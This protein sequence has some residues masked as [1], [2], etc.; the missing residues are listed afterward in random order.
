MILLISDE[1]NPFFS[2]FGANCKANT[3]NMEKLCG[4]GTLFENC[5]TPSPL[6]LPARSAFMAGQY[7][8]NINTYNNCAALLD[9]VY[10]SY[11]K[12]LDEQ[13]VHTVYI[14]KTD[15]YADGEKLGFSEMILAKNRRYPGDVNFPH[16]P[17]PVRK[18]ASERAS[19][20]GIKEDAFKSDE[21]LVDAAIQWLEKYSGDKP[22]VMTVCIGNPHFP[23]Y[24]TKEY[25]DMYGQDMMPE[26]GTDCATAKH[27]YMAAVREH[28]EC[29]KFTPEQAKNLIRGYRADISFVDHQLGR[30]M[31]KVSA[32]G[33]KDNTNIIYTSDHG[34]MM[35][36]FGM[37]WKCSLLEDSVRVP[38]IAAG[39]LFDKGKTIKTPVS[40]LDVQASMFAATQTA[41]PKDWAGE[42][43]AAIPADDKNRTVFSE[44]HGHGEP[45][46][47]FMIRK[48]DYKLIYYKSANNVETPHLLFNLKNDPNELDNLLEKE[49][50]K[51]AELITELQK[52]CDPVK[53]SQKIETFIARQW[54]SLGPEDRA[55][56][57]E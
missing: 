32:C 19:M 24:A 38:C 44:Y 31:E 5:Y 4:Q 52:I 48:G 7:V 20:S 26:Y 41:R 21:K 46:C 43:L 57:A 47:S 29:G 40:L 51:A 33:Y 23:Q 39:P 10:P 12:A 6:C 11:G 49:P 17:M 28:F 25:W 42:N 50:Q 55:S 14:G 53:Q 54:E 37:W 3:P 16:N 56:G 15:V 45:G 36:K 35:G 1:H 27:P 8:H 18:G 34:D 9:T 13:G 30:L 2:S 22:F